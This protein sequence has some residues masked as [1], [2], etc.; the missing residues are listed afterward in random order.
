MVALL[1]F[2]AMLW[3]ANLAAYHWWAADFASSVSRDWDRTW[4]NRFAILT[5]LLIRILDLRPS[6]LHK[7]EIAL[8]DPTNQIATLV[9]D[10]I[11]A[12]DATTF[13]TLTEYR[14]LT[15]VHCIILQKKKRG[16]PARSERRVFLCSA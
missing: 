15:T 5:T 12:A 9:T 11:R 13:S 2:V 7:K 6:A 16:V 1:L 3:S 4:G 14:E 10:S 8:F